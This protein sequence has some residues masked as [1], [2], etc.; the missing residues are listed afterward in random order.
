MNSTPIIP[1]AISTQG[2]EYPSDEEHLMKLAL[3][4]LLA[5][6]ATKV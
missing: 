4:I 3:G 6:I 2:T 5:S 1:K